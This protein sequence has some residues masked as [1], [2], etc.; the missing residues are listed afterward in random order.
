MRFYLSLVRLTAVLLTAAVP[1]LGADAPTH[2]CVDSTDAVSLRPALSRLVSRRMVRDSA[3]IFS[4]TVLKIEH[5][6]PAGGGVPTTRITF[7]VDEPVR[8]VRRGEILTVSEWGGL[9]QAGER[10]REGERV[11]LFLYP[12]S[13]LGLTSPVGGAR[14]RFRVDRAGRVEIN[15]RGRR[16]AIQPDGRARSATASAGPKLV[17]VRRLAAEIRREAAE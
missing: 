13:R 4:G 17:D 9:W 3:Q 6:K 15:S 2:L 10:Y 1:C 11:L 5:E 7:R 16:V 12:P 8:G 14:G